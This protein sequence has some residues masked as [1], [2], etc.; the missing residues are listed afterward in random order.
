MERPRNWTL[1]SRSEA[2]DDEY[3][4]WGEALLVSPTS[5]NLNLEGFEFL[6]PN[7]EGPGLGQPKPETLSPKLNPPKT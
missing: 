6:F 5:E 2:G 1:L 7:P 4:Q 3:G